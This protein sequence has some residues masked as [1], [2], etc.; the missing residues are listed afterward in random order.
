M[1]VIAQ[2]TLQP[3]RSLVMLAIE[4][5]E[6]WQDRRR[7]RRHLAELP[8]YLLKDI[9]LSLADVE[10]ETSKPVWRA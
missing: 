5:F 4:T 7:Q 2:R 6:S 10:R 3:R 8:D 9:G 1:S